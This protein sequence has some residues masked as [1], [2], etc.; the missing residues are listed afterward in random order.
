MRDKPSPV[1]MGGKSGSNESSVKGSVRM[2]D[3]LG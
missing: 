3:E 2:H 1:G